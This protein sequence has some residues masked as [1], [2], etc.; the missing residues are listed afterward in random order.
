MRVSMRHNII[1]CSLIVLLIASFALGDGRANARD[2]QTNEIMI[3]SPPW[4]ITSGHTARICVG[5]GDGSVRLV[6]AG[7]QLLD[8]EGEV[9]AQSDEIR[10]EPGK[11]RFWD[12][13][14]EQISGV[15]EP[16][17]RL[18]LRARI[19]FDERSFDRERPPVVTVEIFD[20]TGAT[21]L[22]LSCS[23]GRHIN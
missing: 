10:V 21:N 19:L 15:R 18:Q 7:I 6:S 2:R 16:N 4:G 14:Y 11:I 22:F 23:T 20:S 8:K 9:V 12:A 13:S 3:E 5:L 1:R 17:G